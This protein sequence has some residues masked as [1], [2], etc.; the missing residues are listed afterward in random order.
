MV[1]DSIRR[2]RFKRRVQ[3]TSNDEIGYTAEAI[4]EMARG[5]EEREHMRRSLDL[6]CEVQQNLLPTG[7]P[8]IIGLDIAGRSVFCDETG[9]DYYDYMKLGG[10]D[11][12]KVV[13]VIGDV[14]DHGLQSALLMISAR[15]FLRHHVYHVH[16]LDEMITEV[17]GHM[18]HDVKDTGRFMTLFVAVIDAS[19]KTIR[20]VRAGRDPGFLYDPARDCFEGLGGKGL[21]LGIQEDSEYQE[22]SRGLVPGQV[23]V[24]ATDGVWEARNREGEPFGKGRL[25]EAVRARADKSAEEIME[26]IWEDL[27]EFSGSSEHQDDV[28]VIAAKLTD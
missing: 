3:V 6:A 15:A 22:L 14:S 2:G 12:Q 13:L 19:E 17:N 25:M 1:L 24:L 9:G 16:D 20:W 5:L 11:S 26:G 8:E 28:T 7:P 18:V 4:N 10:K 21:P 23:I 27:K